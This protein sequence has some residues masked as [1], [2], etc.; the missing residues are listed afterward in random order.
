[1]FNVRAKFCVL[2]ITESVTTSPGFTLGEVV[3][4]TNDPLPAKYCAAKAPLKFVNP[5]AMSTGVFS[6]WAKFCILGVTASLN[7]SPGFTLGEVVIATNVPLPERYCAAKE[8]L[9]DKTFTPAVISVGVFSVCAKFC[10]LG[11][12]ASDKT[13]PGLTTLNV[14]ITLNVPRPAKY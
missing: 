13:S 1:M 6:V 9:G 3:T 14:L 8:A 4:A 7:T 10:V 11:V 2:G 12:I 5:A